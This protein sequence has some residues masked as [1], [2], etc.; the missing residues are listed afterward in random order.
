MFEALFHAKGGFLLASCGYY[1]EGE[2]HNNS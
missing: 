2:L 1:E